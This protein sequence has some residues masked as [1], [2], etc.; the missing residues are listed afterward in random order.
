MLYVATP[1]LFSATVPSVV[2]PSVKVAVPVG[3][4]PADEPTVAVSARLLP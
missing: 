3:V 4:E 2:V 1:V